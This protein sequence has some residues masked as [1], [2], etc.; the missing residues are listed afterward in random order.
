MKD[1]FNPCEVC[2]CDPCDCYDG[3]EPITT[4]NEQEK[5]KITDIDLEEEFW[6]TWGDR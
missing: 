3:C 5:E 6:K 4:K 2:D 1:E